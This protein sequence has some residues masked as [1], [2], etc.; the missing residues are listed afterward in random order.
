VSFAIPCPVRRQAA[1]QPGAPAVVA[2]GAA[3]TW[4]ELDR[5]VTALAGSLAALALPGARVAARAETTPRFVALVLAAFRTGHV[6]VPLSPRLPESAAREHLDR[7]ACEGLLDL[8]GLHAHRPPS[9]VH[10]PPSIPLSRPATVVFTSGST[11]APKAALL[12]AGNHAWSARG[13]AGRLP[14]GAGDRW[15]LDLPLHHVGG[16][17]VVYRCALAG[18]AVAIPERGTPTGEAVR[19]L[20]ATHASLVCTQLY[21]LLR[22]PA[23]AKAGDAGPLPAL[24]ALVLGGSAIPAALLD[25]ARA[26][27]LP[28]ATSYG[29]TEMASTVTATTPGGS[30]EDLATSGRLLP[31]RGLRIREGEIEV[32]GPTRFAGYL[33]GERLETPFGADGWFATGDLGYLDGEGRLVVAGRRDNRFASGGENVQPEAVEAALLALPGVARA[34]VVPVED[35][36]FGARPAAFVAVEGGG[37][38]DTAALG[39]ALRVRLPGY[40]VPVAF[41]P[42]PEG[43]EGLKPSRTALREEAMRR[44][45][46]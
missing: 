34:V 3:W 46:K 12:T 26:R 5:E 4:A 2:P 43:E 25:E 19:A 35:A 33:E 21:R 16:L 24:R 9:T 32:R 40:L 38:P 13:W 27:G 18:A 10:R 17:A 8:D 20:G 30:R 14:L 28:V 37:P 7:V 41:L 42:W 23:P 36:E 44:Q 29:L 6:L 31:H 45:K 39:E 15:L 1:R 11:G 22:E